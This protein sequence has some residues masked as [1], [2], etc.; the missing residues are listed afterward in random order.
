MGC[1]VIEHYALA[2]ATAIDIAAAVIDVCIVITTAVVIV[3]VIVVIVTIIAIVNATVIADIA[4]NAIVAV[5]WIERRAGKDP[6][7]P[8]PRD[9]PPIRA[10]TH[11]FRFRERNLLLIIQHQLL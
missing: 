8:H 6:L 9:S 4:G 10:V 3:I 5:L 2:I 7:V 1:D 11:N